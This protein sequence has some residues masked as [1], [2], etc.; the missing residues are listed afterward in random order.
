MRDRRVAVG[1]E[2]RRKENGGTMREWDKEVEFF[3]IEVAAFGVIIEAYGLNGTQRLRSVTKV[4]MGFGADA[5][6]EIYGHARVGVGVP[7]LAE[8][9]IVRV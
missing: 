9:W 1:K 8:G 3:D 5:G 7:I 4:F 6:S 2:R